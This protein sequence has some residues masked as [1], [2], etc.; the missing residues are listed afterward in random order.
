ME[1]PGSIGVGVL[2][3][4]DHVSADGGLRRYNWR[5][6]QDG[7]EPFVCGALA[8]A[9]RPGKAAF[10][11][12]MLFNFEYFNVAFPHGLAVEDFVDR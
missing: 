12:R 3:V 5:N 11:P 2:Y 1:Q 9:K 7:Y 4:I 6:V 8:I 10:C